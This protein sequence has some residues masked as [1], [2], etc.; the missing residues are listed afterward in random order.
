[1]ILL[2]GEFMFY[3]PLPPRLESWSS[4]VKWEARAETAKVAPEGEER[5]TTRSTRQSDIGFSGWLTSDRAT[6]EFHVQG[7]PVIIIGATLL[8]TLVCLGLG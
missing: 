2:I 5:K 7:L 3:L 6:H 1:M 8:I 4:E